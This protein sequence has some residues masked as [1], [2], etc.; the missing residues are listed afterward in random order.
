MIELAYRQLALVL[1]T[2]LSLSIFN[3][4]L[5]NREVDSLAVPFGKVP[6][7]WNVRLSPDGSKI[8]YVHMAEAGFPVAYI[9]SS[10]GEPAP[11][12][13]SMPGKFDVR[14]CQWANN[15]RLLCGFYGIDN[16]RGA[17]FP[18]TRLVSVNID[19]SDG[20]VLLK[21]ENTQFQDD[22]VDW[23][24]EDSQHVLIEMPSRRGTGVSKLN[25]YTGQTSVVERDRIGAG[26][27]ISDGHGL[28]RLRYSVSSQKRTWFFRLA[29]SE[30]WSVL[31]ETLTED[32]DSVYYPIGFGQDRNTLFVYKMRNGRLALVS[33]DLRRQREEQVVFSH[34]A[35]DISHVKKIGRFNR[36]VAVGYATDKLHLHYIDKDIE[37]ISQKIS[38]AMPGKSVTVIDESWDQRFYLVLISSDRDPGTYYRIDLQE[39]QMQE[40]FSRRPDLNDYELAVM[41][42]VSYRARDDVEIP[43]YLTMPAKAT[44][45]ATGKAL[46]A[47]IM[48]H[49]GP[50]SRDVWDFNWM[51][52]FLAAKG[53][54][55]LQSNFRGSGGYGDEWVGEGGFRQWRLAINDINDGANWLIDE[56]IADPERICVIGWSYGGYAALLSTLEAPDLYQCTVSIA[57]VTDPWTL[58]MDGRNYVGGKTSAMKLIGSEEETIQQGSPLKRAKEFQGPIMLFH[59]DRDINVAVRHSKKMHKALRK[60]DKN[61]ELFLYED[62][63][64]SIWRDNYRIDMLSK[65]GQFLEANIGSNQGN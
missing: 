1:I 3:A 18:V 34:P 51:S 52:Q 57:G 4:A 17:L 16:K 15:E 13:A 35:V 43:S 48:P 28:V 10:N 26:K 63:A 31:H 56:G 33:E 24:P 62:T 37:T 27:W 25:I 32:V 53:Y 5:A 9:L 58:I 64:H 6:D 2:I 20:R 47:V 44:A 23:L 8:S 45:T 11:V 29:D 22:I 54:A 42:P 36:F 39:N 19:G 21:Y 65:I 12:I 41:D 59:G 49:G 50:E 46:P 60:A 14:W 30:S 61:T 7:L 55:V 38:Q 40:I